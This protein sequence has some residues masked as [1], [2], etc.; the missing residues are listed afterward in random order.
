ME[1]LM[2]FP[3]NEAGATALGFSIMAAA[4]GAVIGA[5]VTPVFGDPTAIQPHPLSL[6]IR[7]KKG[8]RLPEYPKRNQRRLGYPH[9]FYRQRAITW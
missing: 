9:G 7:G 1:R 2:D 6:P 5:V 4:A 3:T 8:C